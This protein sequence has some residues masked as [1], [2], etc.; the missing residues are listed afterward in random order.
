MNNNSVS[1]Q[2]QQQALE[3]PAKSQKEN[4]IFISLKFITLVRCAYAV[5]VLVYG[6]VWLFSSRYTSLDIDDQLF[7]GCVVEI[8]VFTGICGIALLKNRFI[9]TVTYLGMM[10]DALLAAFIV[11]ITGYFSSPFLYL[12]LII[13]LYGGITLQ[14]KGGL[15]G[16]GMV[17]FVVTLLAI[18]IENAWR[19]FPNIISESLFLPYLHHLDL[20]KAFSL[21]LAGIGVGLLT[22]QLAHQYAKAQLNL[23]QNKREFT[24]LRGIYEL[25]LKEIPIGVIIGNRKTNKL[26]Y[27]NLE[28]QKLFSLDEDNLPDNLNPSENDDVLE[29]GKIWI[30]LLGEKYLRMVQFDVNLTGIPDLAGYHI[31]D[32]TELHNAQCELLRRQRLEAL[33]EFSAKIAHEIRNPLACISGCNE[34]LQ[35]DTQDEE[36]KQILE[37][38]GHEIERLNALINDILVFSR[39]PKLNPKPLNI[40][41]ILD[42]QKDI[43]VSDAA[44][45]EIVIH[46]N[47]DNDFVITLD[48]N[49]FRQIVMTLWRNSSEATQG[50]GVLSVSSSPEC[51][52][53]LFQDNG[54]GLSDDAISHLFEP[55][56][57]TKSS[58]TGLGLSTARQLAL[59][60]EFD[61]CWDN[62]RRGF[63][64]EMSKKN[65]ENSNENKIY[66]NKQEWSVV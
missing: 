8:F 54:P 26:L 28:A 24:H 48:E 29:S 23:I 7:L 50:T 51:T 21:C 25:L 44:N 37:M 30:R 15:I 63:V 16:A 47:V 66:L 59:D 41:Q 33:G 27:S 62:E 5:L 45:R 64:L 65:I 58:G 11:L 9:R 13:P 12:F 43:F 19:Y 10:H 55:F 49:S 31:S 36:Q 1:L 57:T 22:G 4:S 39:R 46:L 35:I 42:A 14:R 6:F 52:E 18:V 61:L 53:L 38:M 2:I 56:Y 34:M 3:Q 40:R 17:C 32:I 20:S 60:N